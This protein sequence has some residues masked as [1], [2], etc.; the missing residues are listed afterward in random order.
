MKRILLAFLA[1]LLCL[2]LTGCAAEGRGY[3]Q[4]DQETA[5]E[6]MAREDGYVIVDVRRQD[7]YDAGHIPG[8]GS[9]HAESSSSSRSSSIR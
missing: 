2:P 4:I 6:M 9:C 7:E 8:A 1:L 5:R 3:T